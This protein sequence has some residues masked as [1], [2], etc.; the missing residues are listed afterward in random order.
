MEDCIDTEVDQGFGGCLFFVFFYLY[1]VCWYLPVYHVFARWASGSVLAEKTVG[2]GNT[3]N[4]WFSYGSNWGP[5]TWTRSDKSNKVITVAALPA[6]D[7][8]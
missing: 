1:F 5:A 4:L 7:P 2:A 6:Q 8:F 3:W